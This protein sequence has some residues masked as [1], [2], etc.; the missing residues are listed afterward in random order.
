VAGADLSQ[1]VEDPEMAAF[2]PPPS[3]GG[4]GRPRSRGGGGLEQ[5]LKVNFAL[6]LVQRLGLCWWLALVAMCSV[7]DG[8]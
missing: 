5:K 8:M 4:G 6:G 3:D 7:N 2:M 1:Y